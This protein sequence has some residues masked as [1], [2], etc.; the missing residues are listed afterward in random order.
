MR[1]IQDKYVAL[2]RVLI[3]QLQIYA[4]AIRI[5]AN[6]YFPNMLVTPSKLQEILKDVKTALQA[7]NPEYD[8]V[9]DRLHLYYNMQLVTFGIERDKNLIIQFLVFMAPYTQQPLILYQLETVPVPIVDQN[10]QVHS[11]THLQIEKPYIALNSETYI[12]LQ[13]QELRSCKRIGYEFYCEELFMVKH[14]SKY[15]SE[16]AIHFNLDTNTIKDNCNFKFYYNKTN[17]SPRVLDGGNEIILA[18]WPNDKHILCNI[19][20]DIPVRIPSHPYVLIN[21]NVLC[22]CGIEAD[23]HYLLKSLAE[24]DNVNSKLIMYFT[25]N[26]AFANYLDMF[27]N[28]TE[29]L[30]FPIIKNRTTIK[31]ILP[32]SLNISK[33]DKTLIT[34]STDLKAFISSYTKQKEFFDLQQRHDA[35]VKI[36]TNKILL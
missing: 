3:T 29:S 7:T 20:N 18:N 33:F 31:Q 35:N 5:L 12:S 6:G 17:I 23:N 11:Y 25:I 21:R 22:N 24:C 1:T 8:L 13:Q 15:S 2:Y 34:G 30:E 32:V 19:N 9:I 36:N 28:L 26:T 4:S 10:I 14:K 16:S 27:P